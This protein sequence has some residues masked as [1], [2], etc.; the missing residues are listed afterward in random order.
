MNTFRGVIMEES[1]PSYQLAKEQMYASSGGQQAPIQTAP[2]FSGKLPIKELIEI[3]APEVQLSS[4]HLAYPVPRTEELLLKLDEQTVRIYSKYK[5]GILYCGSGQ[6]SEEEMYNNK[7]GSSAFDEFLDMLGERVRLK[8]FD[9]YKGGLDCKGDTTGQLSV[10]TT[11]QQ[12]EVMF[13]VSTLLPFT[14][15]NK[16]QRSRNLENEDNEAKFDKHFFNLRLLLRSIV[17]YELNQTKNGQPTDESNLSRKRHIGNDIVTIIFQDEVSRCKDVPPFGPPIHPAAIFPKSKEFRDFLLT[18]A[19][20]AENAVHRSDKFATMAARTRKEFM[21]DLAENHVTSH[22]LEGATGKIGKILSARR[23]DRP[24]PKLILNGFVRGCIVWD[25]QVLVMVEDFSLCKSIECFLGISADYVVLIE[26]S[27]QQDV[28]FCT[29]THSIIGWTCHKNSLKLYYDH[30]E[31]II[32]RTMDDEDGSDMQDIVRRLQATTK[33]CDT[34][35]MILKRNIPGQLGFHIQQ[36]GI[37]SKL[38]VA[39]L[40]LNRMLDLLITSNNSKVLVI[41]PLEDGSPR[42]GCEDPYCPYVASDDFAT[43]NFLSDQPIFYKQPTKRPAV[44]KQKVQAPT[45]VLTFEPDSPEEQEDLDDRSLDGGVFSKSLDELQSIRRRHSDECRSNSADMS[46]IT[47]NKTSLSDKNVG[48]NGTGGKYS[49]SAK[50]FE[51][52]AGGKRCSSLQ[53]QPTTTI[54]ESSGQTAGKFRVN[55]ISSSS[56]SETSDWYRIGGDKHSTT[57]K[58]TQI[59]SRVTDLAKKSKRISSSG[60]RQD[61]WEIPPSAPLAYDKLKINNI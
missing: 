20:N 32:L 34:V 27:K 10:Y 33:G 55:T 45:T 5:I 23:R 48:G 60:R 37:I 59:S 12:C 21:K 1:L 26:K 28:V 54:N 13:H 18:K 44:K 29:P 52:E 25:V 15:N 41:P 7:D 53:N 46:F 9:K 3:T 16:Q 36:E 24:K 50:T 8:G 17:L 58:S 38:S 35:E 4:L 61:F 19:I 14:S 11:Y 43:N 2:T 31:M 51:S 49:I 57:K 22:C 56:S 40:T 47:R 30:A 6:N 39:T 42:R